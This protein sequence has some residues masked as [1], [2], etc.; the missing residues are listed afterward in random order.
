MPQ[1]TSLETEVDQQAEKEP[2]SEFTTVKSK[3][4][5]QITSMA[6]SLSAHLISSTSQKKDGAKLKNITVK[7]YDSVNLWLSR[8]FR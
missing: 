2:I 6:H 5:N 4:I 3:N 8:L 1:E 7:I